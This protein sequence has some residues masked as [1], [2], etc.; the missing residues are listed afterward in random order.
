MKEKAKCSVLPWLLAFGVPVVVFLIAFSLLPLFGIPRS[1]LYQDPNVEFV[2]FLAYFKRLILGS[3]SFFYSFNLSTGAGM[4]ALIS[5]YLFSPFNL[6]AVFVPNTL[7]GYAFFAIILLE[8]GAAGLSSYYYFRKE[9]EQLGIYKPLIFAWGVALSAYMLGYFEHFEWL[10]SIVILPLVCLGI[11]KLV[12]GEAPW[13]YLVSLFIAIATCYYSGFMICIF[14][15]IWFIYKSYIARIPKRNLLDSIKVFIVASALSGAMSMFLIVPTFFSMFE[16]TTDRF[17]SAAFAPTSKFPLKQLFL[18]LT[19][20]SG[21]YYP[22]IFAGIV[23][24]VFATLY[25]INSRIAKREKVA[26]ALVAFVLVMSMHI[27]ALCTFWHVGSVERGAPFRFTFVVVFF[28]ATLAAR[29]LESWDGIRQRRAVALLTAFVVIYVLVLPSDP[30]SK[31]NILFYADLSLIVGIT[32][33]LICTSERKAALPL[34]LFQLSSLGV[35]TLGT[36]VMLGRWELAV[37]SFRT[38]SENIKNT[39]QIVSAIKAYDQSGE[40]YRLEKTFARSMN[41]GLQHDYHGVTAYTSTT[42]NIVKDLF[43]GAGFFAT[44]TAYDTANAGELMIGNMPPLTSTGLLGVKYIASTKDVVFDEKYFEKVAETDLYDGYLYKLAL[45]IGFIADAKLGI[46]DE[47]SNP[48]ERIN[49]I[50]RSKLNGD[51]F[52]EASS[53]DVK[54]ENLLHGQKGYSK[55]IPSEDAYITYTVQNPDNATIYFLPEFLRSD[56]THIVQI[57][58]VLAGAGED[59]KHLGHL[60]SGSLMNLGNEDKIVIKV[61]VL[62]NYLQMSKESFYIEDREMS[63]KLL[64]ALAEQS[65]RVKKTSN[66]SLDIE[67]EASRENQQLVLTMEYDSGWDVEVDGKQVT[68]VKL[69]SGLIGIPLSLGKHT[70][71]MKYMPKGWKVGM[72]LSVSGVVI[73]GGWYFIEKRRRLCQKK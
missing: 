40:F 48:F 33:L 32:L 5:F 26:S 49:E 69:Y 34:V 43:V 35:F 18:Q 21:Y 63:E 68:P 14:S 23:V 45:P 28:L 3:E 61:K 60:E 24:S 58:E 53:V 57:S 67:A 11:N 54:L 22:L 29:C 55:I 70:I 25:F 50:S 71:K 15:V 9:H 1:I 17:D 19:S 42:N 51:V 56:G 7:L 46:N 31:Q 27:K 38:T 59:M 73:A 8:I 64:K 10:D 12:R 65:T 47:T 39:E 44:N 66:T 72:M 52:S 30:S 13:L 2:D 37:S 36:L 16:G 4:I 41:D 20:N 6:L 62:V